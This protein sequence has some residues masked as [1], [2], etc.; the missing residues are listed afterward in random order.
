MIISFPDLIL[1][2]MAIRPWFDSISSILVEVSYV[3][4]K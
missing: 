1:M 3:L 4:E 2:A